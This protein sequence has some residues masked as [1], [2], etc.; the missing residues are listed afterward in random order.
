MITEIVILA[1][2]AAFLG[3]RL[4]SVL[5]QRSEHEEEP[6]SRRYDSPE[7]RIAPATERPSE[8]VREPV[9]LRSIDNG[10]S[11]N[12]AG[13][14]AIASADPRFDLLGFLEGAKAAYGMILEAF[15]NG[16]KETLRDLTDDDVY[17]G[18]SSAIDAREAAGE[19]LDNRLIRIEDATIHSAEL[20]KRTAR[21]AVLFVSDIASVTRDKDGNVV[22]GSLDDAVESRD[23]WTFTR[24]VDAMDPNWVLDETDQA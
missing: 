2:I 10:S 14:R 5:G 23:I 19:T 4:Y 17:A 1:A 6:I 18:F 24:N 13:V 3:L 16:D 22:A 12:E 8:P 20:D 9:R 15:W 11:A 7:N 21:I